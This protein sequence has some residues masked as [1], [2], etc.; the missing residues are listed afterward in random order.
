M[1][2]I[3]VIAGELRGRRLRV[4][5]GSGV[6][7]TADRVREALFDILGD[8][9]VGARVLDLFAGSG[10]LGIEALSRGAR[11]ASFVERDRRALAALRENLERL[12]LGTRSTVLRG[13]AL[14]RL[15]D[16]CRGDG[17]DLVL[18]DPPYEDPIGPVL[19]ALGRPGWLTGG[20]RVVF[21]RGPGAPPLPRAGQLSLYRSARYGQSRLDFYRWWETDTGSD[22]H[23]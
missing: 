12:G 1:G 11:D 3:R 20:A 4:P 14:A 18:A 15:S 19:T 17:F 10:A 21:E 8:T 16:E 23:A 22:R 13:D 6:R 9:V 7:P 5:A 2:W